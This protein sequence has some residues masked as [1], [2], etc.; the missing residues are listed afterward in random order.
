MVVRS[1]PW[2]VWSQAI[3]ES[4]IESDDLSNMRARAIR[5][6]LEADIVV[7]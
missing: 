1:E 3:Y 4:G 5:M 7:K 6:Y 2:S